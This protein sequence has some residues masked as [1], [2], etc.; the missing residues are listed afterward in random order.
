MSGHA[1]A[2]DRLFHPR[3]VAVAGA[4]S[5]VDS[6]GHDYVRSLQVLGFG[7]AVYP[8][9]PKGSAVAG[10]AAAVS[11]LDL[12]ETPDLVI[13]CVPAGA[14]LELVEQ[15]GR[16]GV[17]FLH[18]FTARFSETG[19]AEAAALE[20][21]VAA[22]AR[23]AGV[24]ILG[25][26]GL[27]LYYPAAGLAFRPD[28][29]AD[30]GQVAFLSQS[31]NNAVEVVL[32]GHARGLRFGKVVNYGNGLDVTPAEILRYLAADSETRVIGAYVE[33]V[34]DGRDF[35]SALRDAAAS[36]TVVVHKA[37]RTAAGAR[38]AA[39]HTAALAGS[40]AVWSAALR[41]AGAFE[42][43][44][45][46]QLLD[47][48]VAAAL[49]PPPQGRRTAVVGGGGGRSVQSADACE[50]QGLALVPLPASVREEVRARAPGLADWLGNPVDQSILAGSGL[51]SNAL[52]ETML[53]SGAYDLAVANVGEDWFFGRPGGAERLRHACSR[54]AILA[55]TAT[56]PVAVVLGATESDDAGNRALSDDV[57]DAFVA[58]G[59]AVFPSPERA[60]FALARLAPPPPERPQR[61]GH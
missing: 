45:Q 61:A 13:S 28:L 21:E 19:D 46:E 59:V 50:E 37:G 48:L 34:P 57:R 18:L 25:P 38:A 36:K 32:R 17:P 30:A 3:A 44:G 56:V 52:L 40:A 27:G 2:L 53:A 31:G 6:P 35:F 15:C 49:L 29:P 1:P 23:A 54:L 42:A 9:N 58:A 14:V 24:R 43:R 20:R 26:N 33:G 51:S 47:L 12:P 4:S 7:G 11:L 55:Q 10:L 8:I 41:Q 22:R 5:N 60:A 16:R 39:S